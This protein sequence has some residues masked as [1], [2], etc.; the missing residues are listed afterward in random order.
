MSKSMLKGIHRRALGLTND[1]QVLAPYGFVAGGD[2]KPAVVMPGAPDTTAIF[3]DF[4]TG[5]GAD[6]NGDT[7]TAGQHF[8]TRKGDTGTTGVIV[9]GTNGVFRFT[10][11]QTAAT[12]SV[13][14]T[15]FG[16]VG[17]ALAWKAN[18][19]PGAYSGRLRF[20][21]RIKK[22]VYTG[23]EHG[24]FVGFTDTTAAEM[25]VFD[26]GGTADKAAATDAVGIGWNLG[27]STGW[28]G[29]GVDG[30]TVQETT[31]TTVAPTANTYVT[32]E[33][34]VHR[35]N[36]DTGGTATF[37]VDGVPKGTISKPLNTSTALTPCIFGYDTGGASLL[38]VDW[39]AVSSLRDTG[40]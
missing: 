37:Y 39:V 7:G 12:P 18:Q 33:V 21:A 26:T 1:D 10:A 9:A 16:M 22:S 24:V 40:M 20:G 13:A 30:D 8:I 5:V 28:V 38:D 23:G 32:L 34:E 11:S 27:G 36:S 2:G 3:D 31:L 25:P 29:Y 15:T 4:Y 14:G 6:L 17:P 35:S 19:G